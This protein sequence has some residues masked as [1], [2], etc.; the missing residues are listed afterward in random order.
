MPDVVFS[1]SL[2]E[3][4]V[5]PLDVAVVPAGLAPDPLPGND[6]LDNPEAIPPT[7]LPTAPA[8]AP[9]SSPPATVDNPGPEVF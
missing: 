7:R 8:I 1:T 5:I 3:S 9:P 4:C 2:V 6:M